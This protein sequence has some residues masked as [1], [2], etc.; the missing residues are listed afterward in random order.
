MQA[1]PRGF[2]ERRQSHLASE[3]RCPAGS[4]LV[5]GLELS[6]SPPAHLTLRPSPVIQVASE[7]PLNKNDATSRDPQPRECGLRLHPARCCTQA[8]NSTKVHTIQ[9]PH[10]LDEYEAGIPPSIYSHF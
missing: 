7:A 8:R 5:L 10:Q 6:R 9:E 3:V 4:G 1:K 2:G